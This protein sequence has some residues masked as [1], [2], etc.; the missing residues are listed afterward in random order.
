MFPEFVGVYHIL[1]EDIAAGTYAGEGTEVEPSHPD[2]K[3]GVLLEHALDGTYLH[4]KMTS[5][6]VTNGIL[7]DGGEQGEQGYVEEDHAT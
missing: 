4:A 5:D 1:P 3:G 6:E 2:G 7:K